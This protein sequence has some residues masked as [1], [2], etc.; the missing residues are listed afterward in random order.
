MKVSQ[1]LQSFFLGLILLGLFSIM[2]Q[3]SY[4]FILMGISCFGLALLYF[5]QTGW[6][7]IED[8]S[9][10]D[11]KDIMAIS[12]LLLLSFLIMLFGFRAFY[13]KIPFSDIIFTTLCGLLIIVYFIIV[14][15]ISKAAKG[16]NPALAGNVIFFYSS[17]LIF[18]LSLGLRIINPSLSAVI[19]ALGILVSLPFLISLF[20]NKQYEYSGKSVTMFQF[21]A[22]SGNKAGMLFLFFIFSAFYVGLSNFRII[23]SI[24]NADKP[25]TYIELINEAE[26]GKDKPVNGKYQHEIYKEAMDKF[27]ERH[28]DQKA[29]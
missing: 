21:V 6:K 23:P 12:E 9:T 4:G 5:T 15:G 24:E 13:I 19:G 28:G 1:L 20:R 26:T 10:L 17:V 22:A 25:K 11:K 3:N 8:F 29:L 7:V 14:S 27:L 18:M 2:A 16:E